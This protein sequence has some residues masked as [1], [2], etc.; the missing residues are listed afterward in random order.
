MATFCTHKLA[1]IILEDGDIL[2]LQ[3]NKN[4]GQVDLFSTAQIC[5]E[6]VQLESVDRYFS[7]YEYH[8]NIEDMDFQIIFQQLEK[9]TSCLLALL[10]TLII[11]Q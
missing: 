10:N 7:T 9:Q 4:L 3:K 11:L 5:K 8:D 1:D 2:Q 6:M